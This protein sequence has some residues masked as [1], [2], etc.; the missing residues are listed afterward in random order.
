VRVEGLAIH[1]VGDQ[2]LAGMKAGI[3]LSQRENRPVSIRTRRDNIVAKSLA[4]QLAAERSARLPEKISE[5]HA[6][7]S[8]VGVAVRIMKSNRHVRQR[9][10]IGRRKSERTMVRISEQEQVIF[11]R[12]LH[13][14]ARPTCDPQGNRK[15][16][17]RLSRLR[18]ATNVHV[19]NHRIEG[20]SAHE[21]C[22]AT[23][24]QIEGKLSSIVGLHFRVGIGRGNHSH[25][26]LRYSG[27][28]R[29]GYMDRHS[30]IRDGGD[31][32]SGFG[33][34]CRNQR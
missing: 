15:S 14:D 21:H 25:L 8:L 30:N 10:Q 28:A 18:I 2:N 34:L 5:T 4:T 22:V 31:R 29:V 11:F 32:R 19:C 7:V 12:T 9:F 1:C 23:R 3:D 6:R 20:S 16:L 26:G 17:R 24:L 33:L 13:L 27:S